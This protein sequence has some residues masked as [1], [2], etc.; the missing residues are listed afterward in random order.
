M[1]RCQ[2]QSMFCQWVLVLMEVA[3]IITLTQLSGAV[4]VLSQLMSMSQDVHLQQKPCFMEF[5]NYKIKFEELI[6]LLEPK[7]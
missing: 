1:T 4:T 7:L 2:N 6:Q 3:T 5:F